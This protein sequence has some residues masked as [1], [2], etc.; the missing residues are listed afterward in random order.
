[1][2]VESLIKKL[3]KFPHNAE[4]SLEFDYGG[5]NDEGCVTICTLE[6]KGHRRPIMKAKCAM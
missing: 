1:M 6:V 2:T 4:V 5:E 3:D